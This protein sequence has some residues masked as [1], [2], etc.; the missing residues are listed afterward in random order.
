[1]RLAGFDEAAL[2]GGSKETGKM[3][4]FC[5]KMKKEQQQNVTE[6]TSLAVEKPPSLS[7]GIAT[8]TQF[9]SENNK[10]VHASSS[11]RTTKI[12]FNSKLP[13]SSKLLSSATVQSKFREDNPL[14]PFATTN[15][16]SPKVP[17]SSSSTETIDNLFDSSA[18]SSIVAFEASRSSSPTGSVNSAESF[19]DI[20]GCLAEKENFDKRRGPR[21]KKEKFKNLCSDTETRLTSK[22]NHDA[23]KREEHWR[24]NEKLAFKVGTLVLDHVDK[25]IINL[26]RLDNAQKVADK[27]NKVFKCKLVSGGELKRG[28]D[29]GLVAKSPVPRGRPATISDEDVKLLASLV[30]TAVSIDQSNGSA[31]PLPN[32]DLASIV[33]E[34]VNTRLKDLNLDPLNEQVFYQRVKRKNLHRLDVDEADHREAIRSIWLEYVNLKQHYKNWEQFIAQ[35]GFG[36]KSTE[37][38]IEKTGEFVQFYEEHLHQMVQFDEMGFILVGGAGN[39]MGGRPPSYSINKWLKQPGI[40][41]PKSA[42]R[43]SIMFSINMKNEALPPMIIYQSKAKDPKLKM[44][45]MLTKCHQIEGQFGYNNRRKFDCIIGSSKEGSMTKELFLDWYRHVKYLYPCDKVV[46][47]GDSGPGRDFDEFIFEA[48]KNGDEYFPGFPNGSEVTQDMD[49]L[50]S[51]LKSAMYRNQDCLYKAR[52]AIE[53]SSARI[54]AEDIPFFLF[55]GK[56]PLSDGSSIELENTFEKYFTAGHI[57]SARM[58]TGYCPATREGLNS[59][60][61]RRLV[62]EDDVKEMKER[63][64]TNSTAGGRGAFNDL[65]IIIGDDND[66]E[67]A[68]AS[69]EQ[70]EK[71]NDHL[72]SSGYEEKEQQGCS[73]DKNK[74]KE[75][76]SFYSKMMLKLQRQNHQDVFEAKR[77]GYRLADILKRHLVVAS[78]SRFSNYDLN[79]STHPLT[80]EVEG[81]KLEALV[82]AINGSGSGKWF[83]ISDGGWSM[84]CTAAIKAFLTRRYR[85]MVGKL[86]LEKKKSVAGAASTNNFKKIILEEQDPMKWNAKDL[87]SILIALSPDNQKK[88]I[89][90]MLKK[91]LQEFWQKKNFN[92]MDVER[93]KVEREWTAEKEA[94]LQVYKAEN[95]EDLAGIKLFEALN[96]QEVEFLSL[97]LRNLPEHRQAMV[98]LNVLGISS[99]GNEKNNTQEDK[100][101]EEVTTQVL[102]RTSEL[103]GALKE[104]N[105]KE[106]EKGRK[107]E[108]SNKNNKNIVIPATSSSISRKKEHHSSTTTMITK[109]DHELLLGDESTFF[110]DEDDD[111]KEEDHD[112]EDTTMMKNYD[113]AATTTSFDEPSSFLSFSP[114]PK[115]NSSPMRKVDEEEEED[116]QQQD[117]DLFFSPG[118]SPI[119]ERKSIERSSGSICHDSS[120]TTKE[121]LFLPSFTFCGQQEEDGQEIEVVQNKKR[122]SLQLPT[123]PSPPQFSKK[124]RK[125]EEEVSAQEVPPPPAKRSMIGD[126]EED[127]NDHTHEHQHDEEELVKKEQ[128]VIDL[129]M[130]DEDEVNNDG[131]SSPAEQQQKEDQQTSAIKD[132]SIISSTKKVEQVNE[133]DVGR[134]QNNLMLTDSTV[135]FLLQR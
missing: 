121:G 135:T 80:S 60:K 96:D 32:K 55:G 106:N 35:I 40:P 90:S 15:E 75:I 73:K 74:K 6:G 84:T 118:L 105:L 69:E 91:Q 81:E 120:N 43:V 33:G 119:P 79:T 31:N 30:F 52:Y 1:M 87:K 116:K 127:K 103:L 27:V 12:K 77:R 23:L 128:N 24:Q 109:N 83:R 110:N 62:S 45:K 68:G 34:I 122:L 13:L 76:D 21:S 54:I 9:N 57:Q 66:E 10:K 22:L 5:A 102:K 93:L 38:E 130:I 107:K 4:R 63:A 19:N 115:N 42:T 28:V 112:D 124:K 44:N 3:K 70:E 123:P 47:R 41:I 72:L 113:E 67:I 85:R 117:T 97:K 125:A 126:K 78:S 92:I 131:T 95:F 14:S 8:M 89:N 108:S 82:Q 37:D 134:L 36:R 18:S 71:Q 100:E 86:E 20:S 99:S 58:K 53:G 50:Y 59:E 49:Q 46:F 94:Q 111:K 98:L 101:E 114:A 11:S 129:S 56:V 48:Y 16:K 65:S 88:E 51:A 61:V 17:S 133:D 7:T 39:G 26:E 2:K 25:G 29:H 132:I 64:K 104:W